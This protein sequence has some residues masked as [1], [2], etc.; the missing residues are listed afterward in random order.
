M[1][2]FA[3]IFPFSSCTRRASGHAKDSP[4]YRI[5]AQ[6]WSGT[7]KVY[8]CLQ[9]LTELSLPT[10]VRKSTILNSEIVWRETQTELLN[11]AT[12]EAE[13]FDAIVKA[14]RELGF[15]YCAYGLRMPLPISNPKMM[16]LNNYS[17]AWQQRYVSQNYLAVDPTV[18]H[19]IRSVA[20]L[21]W[22]Q[23]L[24]E[25][26]PAFWEDARGH[27]LHHGWAKSSY[28]AMGNVGM[29]TLARSEDELT[30][31]ELRDNSVR[32][33]WLAQAAHETGVRIATSQRE[34]APEIVL[35]ARE[36]EV[37]RWT[38]EGK[39]SGEV[40]QIMDISERTV[41][42]HITN[43]LVKLGVVNKTAGVV[44]AAMLRLI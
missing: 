34:A 13:F 30:H 41:N 28:D 4:P 8:R 39:T 11:A 18:A 32:L 24:F 42:F 16:L 40:G 19:G 37:L 17:T 25:Q 43:S 1:L 7:V 6:N 31:N 35:T 21:V 15:E 23:A 26:A 12:T 29:L 14:G 36:I 10:F 27:G 5:R 20:P 33:T 22:S 38:A 2:Q 3:G 9:V 44:K